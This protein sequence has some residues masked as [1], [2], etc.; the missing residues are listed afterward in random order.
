MKIGVS[1]RI[2]R[3]PF[4]GNLRRGDLVTQGFA[5]GY[6]LKAPNGAREESLGKT[7]GRWRLRPNLP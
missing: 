2:L 3:I 1:E 6:L 4:R 5:L 7:S